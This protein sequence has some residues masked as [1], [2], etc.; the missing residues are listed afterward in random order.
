MEFG[1]VAAGAIVLAVSAYSLAAP[2]L[3]RLPDRIEVGVVRHGEVVPVDVVVDNWSLSTLA[4]RPLSPGCGAKE[5]ELVF[6]P[7]LSSHRFT[8]MLETSRFPVGERLE[9]AVILGQHQ[10]KPFVRRIPVTFDCRR[11][12]NNALP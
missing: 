10:G 9:E 1:L 7:P 4:V 11:S 12:K 3:V 2:H 5:D 8:I 6:V